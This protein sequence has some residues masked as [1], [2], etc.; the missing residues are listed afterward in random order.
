MKILS[1][2]LAVLL[3]LSLTVTAG[4]ADNDDSVTYPLGDATYDGVIGAEDAR[5]I[6]R[7]VVGLEM[8]PALNLL[9][10]DCDF[11][12]FI[13]AA[14]ARLALRISVGLEEKQFFSFDARDYL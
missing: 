13:T 9:Y 12:G 7:L 11:D 4:A 5:L 2:I 14:D 3:S 6:L 10:S 1:V 8:V